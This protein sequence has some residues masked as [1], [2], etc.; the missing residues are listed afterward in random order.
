MI[1]GTNIDS[2]QLR[3]ATSPHWD[4]QKNGSKTGNKL[5]AF[6]SKIKQDGAPKTALGNKNM[7]HPPEFDKNQEKKKI[8]ETAK[9][10][11]FEF[12]IIDENVLFLKEP[13]ARNYAKVESVLR[14]REWM[15]EIVARKLYG[16][17]ATVENTDKIVNSIPMAFCRKI[18]D[19]LRCNFVLKKKARLFKKGKDSFPLR[20]EF[21]TIIDGEV[22]HFDYDHNFNRIAFKYQINA[23]FNE[24]AQGKFT[25]KF[26]RDFL[27][28]D[29]DG[30][31]DGDHAAWLRFWEIQGYLL[32]PNQAGKCIVIWY[33]LGDDGKS[34]LIRVLGRIVLPKGAVNDNDVRNTTDAFG[35]S[36]CHD[37]LLIVLHETS[38]PITATMAEQWKKISGGDGLTVNRKHRDKI[39]SSGSPKL[40]VIT[41]HFPTFCPG[42][43]DRALENRLQMVQVF[44]P[45]HE[46]DTELE[47]KLYAERDFIVTQAILGYAR[48]K[49]NNFKFTECKKDLDL[50][51]LVTNGEAAHAFLE[52]CAEPACLENPQPGVFTYASEL[53]KRFKIWKQSTGE[54][55]TY[56]DLRATLLVRGFQYGR[57]RASSEEK[58]VDVGYQPRVWRGLKLL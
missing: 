47:D 25:R 58:F 55:C 17:D 34:V 16:K 27:G 56:K 7:E 15:G 13:S 42:V 37:S 5:K 11:A 45:N 51:E 8:R 22:K 54:K 49:A 3:G 33:G 28:L 21:V 39:K 1:E 50:K 38:R 36:S 12:S 52:D 57:I 32:V 43:L 44:R 23:N 4:P 48:L 14:L 9:N 20:K 19:D 31:E 46:K 30:D 41:N 40:L 26:L 6:F 35:M 2:S 10:A 53:R 24:A 18:Y 29:E